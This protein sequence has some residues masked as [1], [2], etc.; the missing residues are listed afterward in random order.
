METHPDLLDP[1]WRKRAE[2]D[3]RLGAK[4]D[5]KRRRKQRPRRRFRMSRRLI[6]VLFLVL[7][8]GLLGAAAIVVQQMRGSSVPDAGQPPKAAPVRTGVDLTRPYDRTPA[9]TWAEGIAGIT[10][11]PGQ[12]IGGFTAVEVDAAYRKVTEAIAATR[13]GSRALQDHDGSELLALLTPNE[14]ARLE[15]TLTSAPTVE[16]GKYLTLIGPNRLLPQPPRMTGSLTAKPG[17]EGELIIHASYATAYAFDARPSEAKSPSDIVPFVRDEQDY[18]IRKAPPFAKAD[19]GLSFGDSAGFT[20][21]MACDAIKTGV[22]APQYADKSGPGYGV[23]DGDEAAT[24]DPTKP[25][26]T[27]DTCR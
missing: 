8:V 4:K 7:T 26:P 17:R 13:L 16:K 12:D 21:R 22:L 24:Y 25:L 10:V 9:A 27:R 3:A 1:D 5:L 18:V 19:A 11:P 23:P 6:V 15:P 2:R 20:S 14:R